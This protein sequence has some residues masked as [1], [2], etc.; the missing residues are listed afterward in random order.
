MLGAHRRVHTWREPF[1]LA[2]R[3]GDLV[4]ILKYPDREA[5][6]GRGAESGGFND[7]GTD[8]IDVE[9][10]G[11]KLHE[12][13]VVTRAAVD[14]EDPQR[15]GVFAHGVEDI[16]IL[17]RDAFEHRARDMPAG[18]I[19]RKPCEQTACIW[20]PMG[21]TKSRK[22]GDKHDVT[23]LFDR[24]RERLDLG[25]VVDKVQSI[26]H[27][28]HRRSSD[29]CGAFKRILHV[30]ANLRRHR[31]QQTVFAVHNLGAGVEQEKASGAVGAFRFAL[32]KT[33]LAKERRLLIARD[34]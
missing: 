10:V 16:A 3:L 11:L 25:R 32:G 18:G 28:L 8:A 7:I 20:A 31:R 29:K 22:R 12:Q 14:L 6:E 30:I 26:A 33:R 5:R 21:G 1:A 24:P 15:A 17:E 19:A 4:T 23:T 13:V 9:N 34:S 2:P 27:P